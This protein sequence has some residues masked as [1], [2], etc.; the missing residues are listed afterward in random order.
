MTKDELT[1]H[2]GTIGQ[3]NPTVEI[4]GACLV[5]VTEFHEWGVMGY[6]QS[7]GV[8]GQQWIRLKYADI[9]ATGGL[10][11]WMAA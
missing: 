5:V 4:F 7:A 3:V 1:R 6:V 9:E 10:P 2:H 11:V 8:K